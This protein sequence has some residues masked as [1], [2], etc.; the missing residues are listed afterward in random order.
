DVPRYLGTWFEIAKF[1]N[2]FQKKCVSDTRASYSLQADGKVRVL[3][4]CVTKDGEVSEALGEARQ[5]GDAT[6]PKLEVRFA[7][8]W[9][10]FIPLVW[11]NYWVIDLDPDYQLVA[12][13]EPKR[14]YLW[15]LSRTPEFNA[16][17]YD[18]LLARLE[19]KGFDMGKLERTRQGKPATPPN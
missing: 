5:I 17:A 1:P 16:K 3:N 10:S 4:R 2:W 6:S 15:V 19:K 8:A 9:L 18:E 13:G 11:G 14:E 12:V 7:P